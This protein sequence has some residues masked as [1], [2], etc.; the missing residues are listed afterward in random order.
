MHSAS[1]QS[2]SMTLGPQECMAKR[3]TFSGS[4]SSV[5][6]GRSGRKEKKVSKQWKALGEPTRC[7]FRKIG[8]NA[9]TTDGEGHLMHFGQR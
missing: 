4:C 7:R 8:T 1:L 3:V 5:T 9:A 2:C 6:E